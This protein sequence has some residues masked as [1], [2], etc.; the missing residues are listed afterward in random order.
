MPLGKDELQRMVQAEVAP[1]DNEGLFGVV[2]TLDDGTEGGEP[3]GTEAEAEAIVRAVH[4]P[5]GEEEVPAL[6]EAIRRGRKPD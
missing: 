3:I 1:W 5:A 2:F 4:G 6:L